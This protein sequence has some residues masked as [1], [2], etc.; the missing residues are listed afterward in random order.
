MENIIKSE[1]LKVVYEKNIKWNIKKSVKVPVID[2]WGK[3]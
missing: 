2:N 1:K 3:Q